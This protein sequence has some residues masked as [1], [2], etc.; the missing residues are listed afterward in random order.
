ME[1]IN[2]VNLS[3]EDKIQIYEH[4]GFQITGMS[5]L[6]FKGLR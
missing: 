1:L 6:V 3:V 4:Y 2:T 5:S